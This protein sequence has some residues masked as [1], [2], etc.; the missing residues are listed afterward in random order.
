M[1][2]LSEA[3]TPAAGRT[4]P[5]RGWRIRIAFPYATL[6]FVG[7]F[8]VWEGAV[9][10]FAV[11]PIILPAPSAVFLE[12]AKNW[13]LL[14]GETGTT[15]YEVVIGFI[16]SVAT[17]VPLAIL[18]TF[19]RSAE[20][21]L[22]PLIIAA[23]TVPKIAVAPILLAWFGFGLR[24]KIIIVVLISFFPILINSVVGMKSLSPQMRHLARSMG[25]SVWQIFWHFQLP[26]ALPSIFAGM[27]VATTL[28][29][30]GAVVAEF[31]GADSGLGYV[32][33]VATSDLNIARQFAAITVLT[34][35]G[36]IFFGLIE[37]SEKLIL[38]WHIS[39]R[40]SR[41]EL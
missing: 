40:G 37:Y 8:I 24:P 27:K 13:K 41:T 31:V 28:A 39:V 19:S 22:Y 5:L 34:V 36:I 26:N 29:V 38:P 9:R 7:L 23:Q 35:A 21:A 2:S 33:M 20:R 3:S 1:T 16:L 10:V 17:A 30:I 25:A 4:S 11:S 12:L 6:T 14:V 18:L 32:I 15:V